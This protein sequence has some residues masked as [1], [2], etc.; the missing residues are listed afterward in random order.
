MNCHLKLTLAAIFVSTILYGQ[1]ITKEEIIKYKV[2]SITAIDENEAVKSIEYFNDNGEIVRIDDNDEK[3]RKEFVYDSN[4]LLTEERTYATDDTTNKIMK[5][6]YDKIGQLIK[7]E[8]FSD[9]KVTTTWI[10]E[11]DHN[12]NRIKESQSGTMVNSVTVFKYEGS[13]LIKEDKTKEA[14]GKEET[15][16]YKYNKS[17]QLAKMESRIYSTNTIFTVK[18]S[19]DEKGKIIKIDTKQ[20]TNSSYIASSKTTYQYNEKGLLEAMTYKDPLDNKLSMTRYII[21][22]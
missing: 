8:L 2:K 17:G 4:R 6:D 19:Y 9:G 22:F 14:F 1:A 11:Y 20:I 16:S 3:T 7:R 5:F 12:G 15:T 13:K 21:V 10:Y 18:F